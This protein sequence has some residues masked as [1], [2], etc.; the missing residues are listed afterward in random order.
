[1]AEQY[2]SWASDP[3]GWPKG[4][5]TLIFLADAFGMVGK[6]LFGDEWAGAE[7]L[8]PPMPLAESQRFLDSLTRSASLA[9][10]AARL[11]STPLAR[12]PEPA[13]PVNLPTYS[14]EQ[15]AEFASKRDAA[16][17]AEAEAA[18]RS[19]QR[20]ADVAAWIAQRGRDAELEARGIWVRG[21]VA[22]LRLEPHVWNGADNWQLFRQCVAEVTFMSPTYTRVPY[23]VFLT[24]D[25]LGAQIERERVAAN[26]SSLADSD[27]PLIDEMERMIRSGLEK[28][29]RAAALKGCGSGR[30][31]GRDRLQA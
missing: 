15:L 14:A 1:M 30:R 2:F 9:R 28:S 8:E 29:R 21:G 7:A 17:A 6:H 20:R 12:Q 3:S 19:R 10:P 23:F 22:P 11:R 25:S 18:T 24:C 26:P 5:S 27:A 31:R 4:P 16:I 13:K